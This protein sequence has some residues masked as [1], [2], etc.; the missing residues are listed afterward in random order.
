[1]RFFL[2]ETKHSA[3]SRGPLESSNE[4]ANPHSYKEKLALLLVPDAACLVPR[5]LYQLTEERMKGDRRTLVGIH[6]CELEFRFL[7]RNI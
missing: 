2:Y 7:S 4:D 1:M 3:S 5:V 6:P